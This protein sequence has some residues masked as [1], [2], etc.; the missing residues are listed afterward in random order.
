MPAVVT[1]F[2]A[3]IRPGGLERA[4]DLTRRGAKPLERTGA[5]SVR[6]FRTASGENYG[7]LLLAIEYPSMKAYGAGYDQIMK[8]DEI[9]SVLA[10]MDAADTPYTSQ[11]AITVSTEI[12]IGAGNKRGPVLQATVARP[13]PGR[14]ADAV[15]LATK[16]GN[17]LVKS[18][19]SSARLFQTGI[20]GSLSML[21]VTT[22]EYPNMATLGEATDKLMESK[23]GEALIND[24]TGA[25]PVATIVSSDVFTELPL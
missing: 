6:A 15:A 12:P 20:G 18:G 14:F 21:L 13:L 9:I 2:L 11:Q 19:A 1:S 5:T 16:A 10:T 17:L 7:N 25:K 4:L 8:D 22:A 3:Q 24:I 23:E